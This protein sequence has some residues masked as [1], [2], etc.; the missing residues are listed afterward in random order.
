MTS[1]DLLL[2][3]LYAVPATAVVAGVGA[4]A[5]YARRSFHFTAGQR[6][7]DHDPR[8]YLRRVDQMRAQFVR[9]AAHADLQ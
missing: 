6:C 9:I 1:G 8:E 2:V 7:G 4:A 3:V 5:L